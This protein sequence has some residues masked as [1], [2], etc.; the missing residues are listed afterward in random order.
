MKP[1]MGRPKIEIDQTSF[2]KLCGLQC[3]KEEIASFLDCSEDKIE[4]WCK[5]TF[6]TTFAVV[7][8]QKRRIGHVSLRRKQWEVAQ[9]G[10]VTMLIWLGKQFLKQTDK[11][12]V[13]EVT[14]DEM[15][16]SAVEEIEKLR[17]ALGIRDLKLV[18]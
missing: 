6:N 5:E 12:M 11:N 2:E 4:R 3:T 15:N 10:N 9:T 18:R 16:E 7:F 17:E 13:A 14:R 8:K 1:K